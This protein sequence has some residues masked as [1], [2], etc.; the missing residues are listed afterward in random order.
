MTDLTTA[1]ALARLAVAEARKL[2]VELL[3]F[4]DVKGEG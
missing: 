4:D 1:R 2:G 3:G